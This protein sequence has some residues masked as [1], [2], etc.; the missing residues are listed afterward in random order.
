MMGYDLIFNYAELGGII[1]TMGIMVSVFLSNSRRLDRV[2]ER[3]DNMY[4]ILSNMFKK[5]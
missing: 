5:R 2:E 4:N 1:A 3:L